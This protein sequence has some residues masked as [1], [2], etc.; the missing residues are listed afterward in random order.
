MKTTIDLSDDLLA[1]ARRLAKQRGVPLRA[2][3]E[4]GLRLTLE[5]RRPSRFRLV[6]RSVGK[7]TDPNPLESRTWQDLR[8]EIYGG[9]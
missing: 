7:P 4:E 2:I 1:R 6:D 3:V 9:R 5:N 8:D